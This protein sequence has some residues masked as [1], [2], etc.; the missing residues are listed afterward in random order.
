MAARKRAPGEHPRSLER[1]QQ[2]R[3]GRGVG[4]CEQER[5]KRGGGAGAPDA[6]GERPTLRQRLAPEP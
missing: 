5:L 1:R 4:G 6:W 2:Q 3:P